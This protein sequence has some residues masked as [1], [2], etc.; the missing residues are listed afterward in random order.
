MNRCLLIP[1]VLLLLFACS[2]EDELVCLPDEAAGAKYQIMVVF[3]PGQLGDRGYADNV[4]NGVSYL[5][6]Y[7]AT[8]TTSTSVDADLISRYDY[9]STRKA[10]ESWVANP[11]NPVNEQ[12][13]ERRLLVLT[14][15]FMLNWLS[16]CK[17]FLRPTDEVLVLK[18]IEED[19]D[20]ANDSLELGNRLHAV[21]ISMAEPIRMYCET[22]R[23]Y[24]RLYNSEG[25]GHESDYHVNET[26][27]PVFR[28]YSEDLIPSRDSVYE[29][30]VEE[31]GEDINIVKTNFYSK[32]AEGYP[33]SLY[34][35]ST[36]EQKMSFTLQSFMQMLRNGMFFPICGLGAMNAG[37]D[38]FIMDNS[39]DMLRPLLLDASPSIVNRSYILRPFDRVLAD[40]VWRWLHSEPCVMPAAEV[41]GHWDG[42][43]CITDMWFSSDDDDG[44]DDDDDEWH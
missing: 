18:L 20:A 21:N 35:L 28:L 6:H 23:W 32:G 13:Y 1:F 33:Q 7:N 22:I 25:E 14:E 4:F 29:T 11:V 15:P 5:I 43:P 12:E 30:M 24:I 44:G 40:W 42:F 10:L 17:D 27:F 39:H 37:I 34:G 31:L 8:A 36:L 16:T 19:V 26:S 3:A 38:Y 9:A 41:H 2:K